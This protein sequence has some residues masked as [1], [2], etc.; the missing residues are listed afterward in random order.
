MLISIIFNKSCISLAWW[1]GPLIPAL[2]M[3]EAGRSLGVIGHPK[4]HSETVGKKK[5]KTQTKHIL[6]P[7]YGFSFQN[8]IS[9]SVSKLLKQILVSSIG[10]SRKLKLTEDGGLAEEHT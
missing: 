1:H 10:Q 7:P 6:I 2:R 8:L 5:K 9:P 4:L 3:A